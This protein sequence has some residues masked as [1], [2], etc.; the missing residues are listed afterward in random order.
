HADLPRGYWVYVAPYWYIWRDLVSA[1][2]KVKRP[3][4]PEQATGQP[5]TMLARDLHTAWASLTEDGDDEWLLLE[6]AEPVVPRA[7]LV[8]ETYKPGALV[9]VTAFNLNGEEVEVWRGA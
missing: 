6:Y 1:T 7:V 8:H 2:P 9:R 3:W 4:G 5:D